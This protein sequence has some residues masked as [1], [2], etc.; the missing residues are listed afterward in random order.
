MIWAVRSIGS[1]VRDYFCQE[2]MS[3]KISKSAPLFLLVRDNYINEFTGV[4]N[5]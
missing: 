4:D 5:Q 3:V 2:L 1:F